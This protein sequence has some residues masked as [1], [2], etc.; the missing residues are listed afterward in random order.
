MPWRLWGGVHAHAAGS[1]GFYHDQEQTPE[2]AKPGGGSYPAY[3]V[4][5]ECTEQCDC[6]DTNPCAEYIFD[7]RGGVVEG[8]NFTEW[9]IDECVHRHACATS[10]RTPRSQTPSPSCP[11]RRRRRRRLAAAAAAAAVCRADCW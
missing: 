7:N 2:H 6:G 1:S 3:R 4:D 5:G 10:A 8:R 11:R 9:F